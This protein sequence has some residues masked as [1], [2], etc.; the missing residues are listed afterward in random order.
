MVLFLLKGKIF[1]NTRKKIFFNLIKYVNFR[2]V[3][4]DDKSLQITHTSLAD[5]GIYICEAENLGGIVSAQ[6]SIFVYCKSNNYQIE[7]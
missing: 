5:Q 7:Y 4:K 6:A 2:A 1:F 3:I